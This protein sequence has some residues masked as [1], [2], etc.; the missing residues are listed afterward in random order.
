MQSVTYLKLGGSLITD[1]KRPHTARPEIIEQA[2]NEIKTALREGCP[3]KLILGHGSGSFGHVPAQKYGTRSGVRDAAGWQGFAEVWREARALNQLVVDACLKANLP[4]VAFPPSAMIISA[5]RQIQTWNVRPLLQAADRGMIP[6]LFGDV[7][8]DSGIGGTILSTED[9]FAAL[10]DH[11][12]PTRVL[13]AGVEQGVWQDYPKCT[14]LIK[15]INSAAYN[16]ISQVAGG[17]DAPDVTG[18]MLEKLRILMALIA[19]Y[20]NCQG[21]IFS[22]MEPGNIYQALKGETPGTAVTAN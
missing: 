2:V 20:P 4:V 10:A 8:F 6:L 17:S 9:L 19:R 13:L 14:T 7:V 3:A 18:G 1:K 21:L 15:Q 11:L 16:E 22:G 5:D 12:P